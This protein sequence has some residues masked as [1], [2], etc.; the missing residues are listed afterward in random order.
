MPTSTVSS[1]SDEA[2]P[3]SG[4]SFS[5]AKL[6]LDHPA[7]SLEEAVEELR[8]RPED[9]LRR[10]RKHHQRALKALQNGAYEALSEETRGRLTNQFRSGLHA[11]NQALD[12]VEAS[13]GSDEGP[14][15]SSSTSLGDVLTG[16]W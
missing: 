12:E 9:E 16:L 10:A 11:L 3:D 2:S 4:D 6:P 8:R 1:Q 13:N 15:S 7:S 5:S 14:S